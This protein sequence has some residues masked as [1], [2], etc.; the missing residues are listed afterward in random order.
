MG[1]HHCVLPTF[2]NQHILFSFKLRQTLVMH[3][4]FVGHALVTP[5][6]TAP[7]WSWIYRQCVRH[8]IGSLIWRGSRSRRCHCRDHMSQKNGHETSSSWLST[9]FHLTECHSRL[10]FHTFST[11]GSSMAVLFAPNETSSQALIKARLH[12][13]QVLLSRSK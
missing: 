12:S 6:I 9:D 2:P 4:S 3:W 5:L 13:G 7:Y 10:F 1:L 11:L 8:L